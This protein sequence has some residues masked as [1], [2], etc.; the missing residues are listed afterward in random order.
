V[1]TVLPHFILRSRQMRPEVAREALLATHGGLSVERCAM[2]G[3]L[4]PMALYRLGCACGHHSLVAVLTRRGLS[5][6][7]YCL[8]AA[9]HRRCLTETVFLPTIVCG[10]VSWHLG[11]AAEASAA[12]LTPSYGELQCAAS[13]QEPSSRVGGILSDG[14][15]STAK[16][17][18]TLCPGVRLGNCLRHAITKL[19]KQ[20]AAIASPV[21]QA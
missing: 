1:F 16:S 7:V 15:D 11:S 20:R 5:L 17:M 10:R 18:Q 14:F 2:L 8:A 21:R 12:A 9:K 6:P 19:P 3:H 4:A 13:Q